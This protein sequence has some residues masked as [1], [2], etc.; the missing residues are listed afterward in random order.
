MAKTATLEK[1]PQWKVTK[2]VATRLQILRLNA[3]D[4]T[5]AGAPQRSQDPLAGFK[6][7]ITRGGKGRKGSGRGRG[8]GEEGKGREGMGGE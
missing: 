2:I 6:L 1:L 3:P 7:L 4:S 5:S 8:G